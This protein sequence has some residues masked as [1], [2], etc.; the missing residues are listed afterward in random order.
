MT[1]IAQIKAREE[2]NKKRF[3]ALN[4]QLTERSGIYILHREENGIK[5][6]YVGQAKH[7]LTRLAQHIVGYQHIDLSIKKHGLANE[8][9]NGW[10]VHFEECPISSLDN[11]ERSWIN[12]MANK[13][14][15]LRNKTIGGQDEGKYG[16]DNQKPNRGYRDGLE[17]GRKSLAKEL[18]HIIKTHDF[19]IEPKKHNKVTEKAR[20]KFFELL[21]REEKE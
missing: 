4:K 18:L 20:N 19:V 15:Q 6:A 1:N 7:I 10:D 11:A 17:Q 13:G 5:Y 12:Y 14:Y 3:L 2:A 16:L 8:K 9:E 21:E